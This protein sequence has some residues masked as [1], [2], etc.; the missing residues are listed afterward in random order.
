MNR[1]SNILSCRSGLLAVI[2]TGDGTLQQVHEQTQS[3]KW[4]GRDS[5]RGRRSCS[6][7][8]RSRAMYEKM[9]LLAAFNRHQ[10]QN[11]K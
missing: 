3:Q 9:A 5:R 2:R 10:A 11:S 8:H 6:D 7:S 1:A 4:L